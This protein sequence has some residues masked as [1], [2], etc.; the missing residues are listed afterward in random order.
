M[1]KAD[2]QE[3]P[4]YIVSIYVIPNSIIEDIERMFNA[5]WWEGGIG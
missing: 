2:L 1:I 5:F 3:I 4:A